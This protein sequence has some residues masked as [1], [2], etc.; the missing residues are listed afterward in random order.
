M[1]LHVHIQPKCRNCCQKHF[2]ASDISV[3]PSKPLKDS[4]PSR[5]S[6]EIS[7]SVNLSCLLKL[8]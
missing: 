4:S 3:C 1:L 6:P 7:S 2:R 5:Q 8:S